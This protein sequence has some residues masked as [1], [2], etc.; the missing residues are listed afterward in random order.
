MFGRII[1]LIQ[2]IPFTM[3]EAC[4]SILTLALTH[5]EALCLHAQGLNCAMHGSQ[6]RISLALEIGV[7]PSP[8]R[9]QIFQ[10]YSAA[11]TN[12]QPALS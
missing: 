6:H 11:P 3:A 10:S 1:L 5:I 2:K 9:S 12:E 8:R 7:T 4:S